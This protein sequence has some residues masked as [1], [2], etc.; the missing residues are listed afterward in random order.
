M[1]NDQIPNPFGERGAAAGHWVFGMESL[2]HRAP[3]GVRE[4]DKDAM[5]ARVRDRRAAESRHDFLI[6]RSALALQP[7]S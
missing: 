7:G 6:S 5:A 3:L 2:L 1:G 4:A